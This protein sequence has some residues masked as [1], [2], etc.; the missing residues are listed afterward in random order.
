MDLDT[1]QTVDETEL[2]ELGIKKKLDEDAVVDDDTTVDPGLLEEDTEK[3]EAE[4]KGTFGDDPEL[5]EYMAQN[6]F[7]A[8]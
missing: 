5:E 2:D 1:N 8:Y 3:E 4:K 7:D 6:G